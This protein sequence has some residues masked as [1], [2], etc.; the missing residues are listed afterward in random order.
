MKMNLKKIVL[1]GIVLTGIVSGTAQASGDAFDPLRLNVGPSNLVEYVVEDNVSNTAFLGL[2]GGQVTSSTQKNTWQYCTG[3]TDPICDP[4]NS[5]SGMIAN[6]YLPPCATATSD[7][8][9][10]SLEIGNGGE[11]VKAR[12][13]RV[14]G[15]IT[16]PQSLE[17]NYLG[18][19]NVSLWDV[20][21]MPSASGLTTYAL[22]PIVRSYFK[23]GAFGIGEFSAGVT[24]YKEVTG[25]YV[26]QRIDP[27][28]KDTPTAP[29]TYSQYQQVCVYEEDGLC[30]VA[31]DF[32]AGTRIRLKLRLSKEVGGWFRGRLK[33]PVLNVSDFSKRDASVTV[34]G[35][36][37]SVPRMALVMP[38]ATLNDQEKI[39]YQNLGYWPTLD[40]GNGTGPQAGLPNDAFPVIDYYRAK[41]NDT[42][43]GVNT[44][45]NFSTTSWGSGS[46]CLQDKTK[47]L[48]IVT[49]NAMAYD[50]DAPS[51]E[52]GSLNY[53]VS[54]LH[55][56]PGGSTP[57]QGTYNLVMRS[58]V[59]RCLYG[60]TNAPIK[61]TISVAGTGDSIVATTVSGESNGWL[62]LAASGFTFSNKTIQ[63]K[64]SQE[65]P[66][67]TPTA[68]PSPTP[69]ASES[70]TP[71]PVVTKPPAVAKKIT[72]TCVKGKSTKTVTAAKPTCP[73]GYK[74]K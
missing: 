20:P 12:L 58:D 11:M 74:K 28:L 46:Q 18:S 40:D 4:K 41:V 14:A 59:A 57:V 60:F 37:V 34:E 7:D 17:Y 38:K 30:G 31:Q 53:H 25:P 22:S 6:S 42:A 47:L 16:F 45:W 65:A 54:G 73:V 52:N 27:N 48:G 24:P 50:G 39:W 44:Y 49:T 15:G 55:Y 2:W 70:P 21:G 5:P 10:E 67:P 13:I 43:S 1:V 71:T 62:S 23:N 61:A 64:L 33:D 3:L 35:T 69:V 9:I 19:S 68:T 56:M 8:C 26:Q 72:I 51:F 29:Y 63:V 32:A 66:A 36:P